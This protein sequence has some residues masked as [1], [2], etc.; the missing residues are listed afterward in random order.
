MKK[1]FVFLFAIM[2]IGFAS[3]EYY[4]DIYADNVTGESS[5]VTITEIH[6]GIFRMNAT[7]GDYETDR[8]LVMEWLFLL[9]RATSTYIINPIAVITNETRDIGATGFKIAWSGTSTGTLTSDGT[10]TNT[11]GNTVSSWSDLEVTH[12]GG[13]GTATINWQVPIAT[14]LNSQSAVS[15]NTEVSNEIGTDLSA[16]EKNDPA[17]WELE[18]YGGGAGGS[19]GVVDAILVASGDMTVSSGT[20]TITNYYVDEGFPKFGVNANLTINSPEETYFQFPDAEVIFN[21]SASI[22]GAKTLSNMSLYIGEVLN[23]TKSLSGQDDTE[24]FTKSFSELGIYNWSVK[25]CDNSSICTI[26]E[27][28]E[29][30]IA[31][32]LL[33]NET[34][35][36]TIPSSA[37]Q[38]FTVWLNTSPEVL[39]ISG[40]FFYQGSEYFVSAE[41][42]SPLYKFEKAI[43]SPTTDVSLDVP[44]SWNI[45]YS[46]ATES[47]N[48]VIEERNQSVTPITEIVVTDSS[49]GAGYFE[50][51]NY[52]FANAQNFTS[53]SENIQYDFHYGI[54]NNTALRKFGSFTNKS[55]FRVCINATQN[56]LELGYGEINYET[57]GYTQRRYYMFEGHE[58]SNSTTETYTLYSLEDADSTSFLF[59]IKNTYLNPYTGK[60]IGLLRWYPELDE[61]RV[62]EIGRTDEEGKTIMKVQ[63]EDV[64]YRVAV[65]DTDGTLIKLADPVRMACLID[66]CTY[67]LRVV[68]DEEDY[69]EYLGVEQSL[70]YDETNSRFVFTWND[71]SQNTDQMRLEVYK[72]AG[73]QQVLICNSTGT[74]YTGVLTCS[75]GNYTGSFRAKAFRTASP[76]TVI[77][78][79]LHSIRTGVQSDFG[80]FLSFV[81]ALGTG[82]IGIFSPIGAIA[83]L[84]IG[85]IPAVIFG[86]INMAIFMAILS[87]GGIIIH[88]LKKQ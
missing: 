41:D 55:V 42:Y 71:P 23:E 11:T 82:L 2:L 36:S 12:G 57:T 15:G 58:L 32:L 53:L 33:V 16:D 4:I 50:A 18:F 74:G 26:S 60:Y 67:T 79:L 87:L 19:N 6:D 17:T 83:L 85:F 46:T 8:A 64:D 22:T 39:S 30:E 43:A 44:F 76:E 13:G 20:A 84:I 28:R 75:V 69:F 9:G 31:E 10:F 63:V 66:P 77:A 38:N 81:F 25:V 80:L 78:T 5:N 24:T 86:A 54:S 1:L 88:Y 49:C 59:E 7:N 3:A 45:S 48:L 73:F 29:L 34:Y 35:S 70:I 61:Y 21:I 62:V 68:L 51:L 47:Y 27:T 14:T 37:E 56:S 52:T 40:S 65:Y 72:D